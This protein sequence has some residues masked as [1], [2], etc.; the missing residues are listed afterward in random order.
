MTNSYALRNTVLHSDHVALGGRMVPF[1]G[2]DMPVQYEGILAEAR[3]VRSAAGIFDVSHMGRFSVDGA[4]ARALLDWVHTADIGEAMPLARARYGLLCNEDGGIID[5]AIVYRLDEERFMIVANA[6]NAP[7][8]FAWL[9]HWRSERFPNAALADRTADI[10]M[11]ALQGP[12]GTRIASEV[13]AFDP[14]TVRPFRVLETEILG[15]PALIARTGYT[16]EDGVEIMPASEVARELWGLLIEKGAAPCG[17]GARDT[18]RLE[19]GL[20][21]HG[22]DMDESVN[23]IEAGLGRF[24]HFDGDFCGAEAVRKAASGGAERKLVGFRTEGR[25]AV[26]RAHAEILSEETVIG[27]VTSGGYSPSLGANVGLGYLPREATEPGTP[28]AV[29]V[30][31]R[32]IPAQIVAL[33]FYKRS[34]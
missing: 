9:E 21:L 1:A 34:R 23:P 28:I 17:L 19:A 11:I 20:L 16:G 15:A 3:A 12:E 29:D 18:L 22:S 31:G 7:R 27:H 33:P 2:Y 25:G 10:A 8:V 26:P 13:S 4:D 5:D 24:V 6:A 14:S 32:Q 30:R